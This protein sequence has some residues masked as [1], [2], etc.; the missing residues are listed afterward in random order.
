MG[1]SQCSRSHARSSK[2]SDASKSL[3]VVSTTVPSVLTRDANVS[4]SVVR[5]LNHHRGWVRSVEH[6]PQSQIRWNR[7]AVSDIAEAGTTDR[8]VNG[9]HQRREAAGLHPLNQG[10]Q[11]P[12][13]PSRHTAETTSRSLAPRQPPLLA[14][15]CPLSRAHT[16][17]RSQTQRT[18]PL[19]PPRGA[20]SE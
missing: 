10:P 7:H 8:K 4:G 6:S 14:M 15:S 18:P 19:I 2:L 11:K 1:P 20:S 3:S 16:E 13:C 17:Y 12:L 9:Q 5:K